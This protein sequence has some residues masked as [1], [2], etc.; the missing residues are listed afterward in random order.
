M[1]L[2]VSTRIFITRARF[3]CR[4]LVLGAEV[5][6]EM[7]TGQKKSTIWQVLVSIQSLIL[8]A[9]YPYFNEP[10]VEATWG[11]KEGELQRRVSENGGYERL[12]VAT[13]KYAMC[14]YLE[15]PPSG[16]E[17]ITRAHF[18]IKR[19]HINSI[20]EK[21]LEEAKSSDTK[22]HH[23]RLEQCVKKLKCLLDAL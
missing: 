11:T 5:P 10:G 18:R 13:I 14:G 21:W 3:V 19:S 22:G 7:K 20:V 8:G 2:F 1:V 4:Y 23:D 17:D 9:E 15:L 16:F 12:R 6:A